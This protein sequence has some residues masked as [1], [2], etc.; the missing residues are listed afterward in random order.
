[1]S[2][3]P[4]LCQKRIFFI[5]DAKVL[6]LH[7]VFSKYLTKTFREMQLYFITLQKSHKIVSIFCLQKHVL[8]CCEIFCPNYH[9]LNFDMFPIPGNHSNIRK[10]LFHGKYVTKMFSQITFSVSE[11]IFKVAAN[12][13]YIVWKMMKYL[14]TTRQVTRVV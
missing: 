9:F 12:Q 5:R 13:R 4:S 14:K 1:M 6:F 7:N 3:N 10:N 2:Q 11:R 8:L